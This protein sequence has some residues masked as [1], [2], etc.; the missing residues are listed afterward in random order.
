MTCRDFI[1]WMT[2]RDLARKFILTVVYL[3]M[4]CHILYSVEEKKNLR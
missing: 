2:C 3:T 1:G 4:I